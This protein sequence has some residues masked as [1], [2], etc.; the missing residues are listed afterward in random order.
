VDEDVVA[1]RGVYVAADGL[2]RRDELFN[3]AHKKR[4][5]GPAELQD[6][7]ATWVPVPDDA[8]GE[9]EPHEAPP[10]LGKRKQ[11]AST[12]RWR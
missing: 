6:P 11:Y 10:A 1:D 7:F 12:V 2:T 8:D 3:V 5:I 4:R 9:V